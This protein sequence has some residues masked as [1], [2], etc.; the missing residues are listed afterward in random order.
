MRCYDHNTHLV[1]MMFYSFHCFTETT[2]NEVLLL[3][4]CVCYDVCIFVYDND[5][6]SATLWHSSFRTDRTWLWDPAT[7]DGS[8]L[9]CDTEH[10]CC[11]WQHLLYIYFNLGCYLKGVDLATAGLD[12]FSIDGTITTN[13]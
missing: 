5:G 4:I 11:V 8:T 13:K 9:Q 6:L 2:E 1:I 10:V 12:F 7:T 3:L